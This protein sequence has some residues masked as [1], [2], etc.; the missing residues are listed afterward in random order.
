M[1]HFNLKI[2]ILL[3][4]FT[5]F[6][7]AD[8]MSSVEIISDELEWNEKEKIAYA[9]GNASAEQGKRKIM[10]D[11]LIVYLSKDNNNADNHNEITI[12]KA[13]GNVKF[14]SLEDLATG[15]NAIYNLLKN[16]V[17][18]T[19][20]VT[21]KRK[22]N[23]MHGEHLE[24]NLNTGVSSI[25]KGKDGEKVKMQFSTKSSTGENINDGE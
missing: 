23:V 18:V 7:F 14:S 5:K 3:I 6:V 25:S 4:I 17:I 10:A 13:V 24:L 1:K 12:I 16:S 19:G 20:N 8:E 15:D 11:E 22:E 2:F 9:R 21:L